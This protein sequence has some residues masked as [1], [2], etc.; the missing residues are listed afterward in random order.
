MLSDILTSTKKNGFTLVEL[1][2]VVA[3]IGILAMVALPNFRN[4]QLKTKRSEL[5]SNL[6]AIKM[7]EISYQAEFDTFISLTASPRAAAALDSTKTT[8]TD[9]GGFTTIGWEPSGSVYGLYE[10]SGA[11]TSSTFTGNAESD[12]DDDNNVAQYRVDQDIEVS[13][14]TNNNI[15]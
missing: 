2:I 5:P 10:T 6:K 11:V 1:M 12:I 7:T 3:I 9:N 14:I 13:L 8:W 15:Y 4:Y